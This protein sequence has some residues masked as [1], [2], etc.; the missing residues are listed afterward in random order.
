MS[1]SVC[2]PPPAPSVVHGRGPLTPLLAFMGLRRCDPQQPAH[3]VSTVIYSG[4]ARFPLQQHGFLVL[5]LSPK[6]D[7]HFPSHLG[8][9]W[10]HLGRKDYGC[11]KV[12]ICPQISLKLKIISAKT[13]ENQPKFRESYAPWRKLRGC[14]KTRKL[15]KSCAPQHRNFLGGGVICRLVHN[16]LSALYNRWQRLDL[17]FTRRQ[18]VIK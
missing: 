15:R 2:H 13:A 14:A 8:Q 1:L 18:T 5:L 10:V 16:A 7:T 12:P 6:S 17:L 9:G 3:S 4:I 11:S